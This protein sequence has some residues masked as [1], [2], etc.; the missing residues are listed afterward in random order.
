MIEVENVSD[1][2][3]QCAVSNVRSIAVEFF[4]SGKQLCTQEEIYTPGTCFVNLL[5]PRLRA[6]FGGGFVTDVRDPSVRQQ[7]Q[8]KGLYPGAVRV[9]GSPPTSVSSLGEFSSLQVRCYS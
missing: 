6:A 9:G 2:H 8:T 1:P 5:I 7:L 3:H 4:P